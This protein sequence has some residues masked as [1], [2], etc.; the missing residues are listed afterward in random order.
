MKDFYDIWLLSRQFYF[1]S[2]KL[3]EAIRLTFRQRQTELNL[4]VDAFT[5]NFINAKQEQWI[6]FYKRIRHDNILE[7]KGIGS[8]RLTIRGL[9]ESQ[10]IASNSDEQGRALNRRVEFIRLS[11]VF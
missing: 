9:G 5:P 3:M 8:N 11:D 10:P 2:F 1:E 4:P 6:A 7:Q